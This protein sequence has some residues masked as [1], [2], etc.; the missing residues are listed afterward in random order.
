TTS[1]STFPTRRSS[2]LGDTLCVRPL[3]F[4]DLLPHVECYAGIRRRGSPRCL[5]FRY[6]R[7]VWSRYGLDLEAT[8]DDFTNTGVLIWDNQCRSEE[9]TSELQ[10]L[11]HL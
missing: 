5:S 6:P 10:S 1:I 4:G 2:D 7:W 8:E 11:R 9:H 3:A